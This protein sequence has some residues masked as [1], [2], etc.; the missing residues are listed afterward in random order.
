MVFVG[1][2]SVPVSFDTDPDS[3]SR[4]IFDTDDTDST[5]SAASFGW[6]AA[7]ILPA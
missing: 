5:K 4:P 7:L 1:S 6:R 3:E 2:G